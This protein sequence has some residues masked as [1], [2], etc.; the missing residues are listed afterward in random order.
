MTGADFMQ[1]VMGMFTSLASADRMERTE[2]SSTAHAQTHCISSEQGTTLT[3][4]SSMI[5]IGPDFII[6][7][8]PKLLLNPG[9]PAAASSALGGVP[10]LSS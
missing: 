2:G 5:H 4:G 9:E 1:S 7:Q 6:I 3:V 8:T 10:K